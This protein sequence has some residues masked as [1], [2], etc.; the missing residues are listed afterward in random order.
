MTTLSNPKRAGDGAPL[1]TGPV[2]LC[3]SLDGGAA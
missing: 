3:A 2:A 1:P